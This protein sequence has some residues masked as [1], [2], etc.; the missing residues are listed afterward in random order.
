MGVSEPMGVGFV[1]LLVYVC[2]EENVV[3]S[4]RVVRSAS[5]PLALLL[6]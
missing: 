4:I 6:V 2:L 3:E 5:L 1:L